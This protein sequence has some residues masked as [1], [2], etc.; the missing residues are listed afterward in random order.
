[1]N[2]LMCRIAAFTFAASCAAPAAYAQAYPTKPVRMVIASTP[3]SGLD[4]HA[5]LAADNLAAVWKQS[6]VMEY[7][8]GG[9]MAIGAS[10]VAKAPPDGYTLFFSIDAPFVVNP[11][12]IPNLPY[13]VSD[14]QPISFWS[15]NPFVL[16]VN[17]ELPVKTVPELL[18][19]MRDNPGKL[20][21]ASASATT[22]LAHELFRSIAGVNYTTITYKGGTES[23]A[24]LATGETQLAIYD[25]GNAAAMIKA[26]KIR[27]IAQTPAK[28]A[29]IMPDLPTVA[30]GGV[31]G[32]ESGTW[33]A[34]FA[35]AGTPREIVDKI[36][37]DLKTVLARPEL[38][39]R[40][41]ELGVEAHHSTPEELVQSIA[42]SSAKWGKLIQERGIK[43]Q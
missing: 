26:G 23:I 41:K 28:R 18:A 25:L 40:L 27:V 22:L 9:A 5:R 6:V 4:I 36:N 17:A 38:K 19:H 34:I 43:L 37:A 12:A 3:A 29:S 11:L 39:E 30:E 2:R 7:K 31:P 15:L 20:N 8:P 35:P 42:A 32:F 14:L 1:M 24:S 16:V 33:G 21:A 13:K 10:F